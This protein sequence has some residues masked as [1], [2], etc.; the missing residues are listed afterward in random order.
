MVK[1][2]E[3]IK[4]PFQSGGKRLNAILKRRVI[5]WIN[6]GF[7]R[8]RVEI[9]DVWSTWRVRD[10]GTDGIIGEGRDRHGRRYITWVAG[11]GR[12]VGPD[13]VVI[14]S[15]MVEALGYLGV[16]PGPMRLRCRVEPNTKGF[17]QP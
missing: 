4:G 11:R 8:T 13:S 5:C 10:R 6:R 3:E 2:V 16:P 1:T 12:E 17:S 9:D 15:K 7:M 14:I